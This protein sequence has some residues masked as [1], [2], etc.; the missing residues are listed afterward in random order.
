MSAP[1]PFGKKNQKKKC[2]KKQSKTVQKH[3]KPNTLAT[4]ITST[5][6][7]ATA[8]G[9]TASASKS[10]ASQP[11]PQDNTKD[12]KWTHDT[13]SSQPRRDTKHVAENNRVFKSA[14]GLPTAENKPPIPAE[15]SFGCSLCEEVE[16]VIS[17]LACGHSFCLGCL[18]NLDMRDLA[19]Y[20]NNI[21]A[22]VEAHQ[23]LP[24]HDVKRL[25]DSIEADRFLK[26]PCPSTVVP[27][28]QCSFLF[29]TDN[30]KV[31]LR[32]KELTQSLLSGD[33]E[34][35]LREKIDNV[36]NKIKEEECDQTILIE[37]REKVLE[38][39][40]K[41]AEDKVKEEILGLKSE[42][43]NL[44]SEIAELDIEL[45]TLKEKEAKEQREIDKIN[46]EIAD[47]KRKDKISRAAIDAEIEKL[48]SE[49]AKLEKQFPQSHNKQPYKGN[50]LSLKKNIQPLGAQQRALDKLNKD[51]AQAAA[52]ITYSY[53]SK[54]DKNI[55]SSSAAIDVSSA[56]TAITELPKPS[57]STLSK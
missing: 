33:L 31:D 24:K 8:K 21:V 10:S 18:N 37:N 55:S 40:R 20:V 28:Q 56:A 15:S 22:A 51:S 44:D 23:D 42:C 27:D 17:T 26:C 11:I 13:N 9:S 47:K 7:A 1:N 48:E 43:E 52:P 29:K 32:L 45:T 5:A 49:N 25:F 50:K 38:A 19:T 4:A 54:S 53:G 34:K 3:A 39:A 30:L 6:N 12:T 2:T 14:A 36:K 35:A 46:T 41:K 57:N 16:G